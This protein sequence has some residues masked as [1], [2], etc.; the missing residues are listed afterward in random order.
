[1]IKQIFI[2]T[3]AQGN[4]MPMVGEVVLFKPNPDDTVA[5]ANHNHDD[6]IA[7]IVTRIWSY[8]CVN[9]KIVPDC[10]P[11]QD[12]T[13]VTH[14]S[15]NQAGYHFVYPEEYYTGSKNIIVNGKEYKVD[16]KYIDYEF[17]SNLYFGKLVESLTMVVHYKDRQGKIL[18]EGGDGCECENGMVVNAVHTGNA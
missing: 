9:L 8:G 15:L 3:D 17:I 5:R 12:R 13:S 18:H 1:M 6:Y 11:M 10:G 2:P 7:A 4:R 14:R 16:E